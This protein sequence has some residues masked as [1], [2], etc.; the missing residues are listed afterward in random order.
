MKRVYEETGKYLYD[1]SKIILA[2]AVITPL[3]KGGDY[4]ILAI[5]GSILIFST[6]AYL[7][8]KGDNYGPSN[9]RD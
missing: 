5:L 1:V 4:S 3:V 9:N 8:H 6:G 2:V 7:I